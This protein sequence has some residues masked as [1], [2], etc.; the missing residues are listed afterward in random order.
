MIDKLPEV[1]TRMEASVAAHKVMHPGTELPVATI[2]S[3]GAE[4]L[5][6]Q[7][8]QCGYSGGSLQ[9]AVDG[10]IW[11]AVNRSNDGRRAAATAAKAGGQ[12][13]HSLQILEGWYMP[14]EEQVPLEI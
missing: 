7:V 2:K 5:C 10:S 8:Q 11:S 1:K 12:E 13:E 3:S 14:E 9:S 6:Q 4:G